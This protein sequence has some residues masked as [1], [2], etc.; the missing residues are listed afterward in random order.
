MADSA[1]QRAVEE[2][3]MDIVLFADRV[4]PVQHGKLY[5]PDFTH[6]IR[7]FVIIDAGDFAK[8]DVVAAADKT[9][10]DIVLDMGGVLDSV[11]VLV[12][13]DASA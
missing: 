13:V 6:L 9:D 2:K 12:L 11:L 1:K 7:D 4:Y 10:L 5:L 8:L 3:I